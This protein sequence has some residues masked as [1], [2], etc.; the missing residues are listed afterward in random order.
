MQF[1]PEGKN[2]E[3]FL[4][5]TKL[6]RDDYMSQLLAVERHRTVSVEEYE[7]AKERYLSSPQ[8]PL[9]GKKKKYPSRDELNDRGRRKKGFDFWKTIDELVAP[10]PTSPK[11][12]DKWAGERNNIDRLARDLRIYGIS[13]F[14]DSDKLDEWLQAEIPALGYVRPCTLLGTADGIQ[15]LINVLGR[16]EHGVIS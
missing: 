3:V 1:L 11:D 8:L 6:G 12:L 2:L 10:K 13:V 15:E 16:I 14:G 9:K 7:N 4:K 5:R